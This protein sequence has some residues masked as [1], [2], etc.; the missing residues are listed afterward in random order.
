MLLEQPTYIR[1]CCLGNLLQVNNAGVAGH[2]IAKPEEFRSFK[3]G[4]GYVSRLNLLSY[5]HI[6]KYYQHCLWICSY[7]CLTS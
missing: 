2:V 1:E 4:A 3:D 6:T 7:I 5:L